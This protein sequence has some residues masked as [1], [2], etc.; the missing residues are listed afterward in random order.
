MSEEQIGQQV[1]PAQEAAAGA[2]PT[3]QARERH[4][5]LSQELT[6]HQYRYY[7]LDTPT[8]PDA[9]F[10][11]QLRELEALEAEF[12]A[13]RTPDSPTQRVGGSF[14]T[15]FTPVAHAERMLSLD[16]AF[17][18]EELAAWAERVERDAGGPVPYLCEL[19]VDGLAINLTY[20]NGR[21]VR[22]ATRG[23]GRTGE[24]VTANV[25]SIR[26]VPSQL[27]PS[28]DF[29]DIPEL[30]EVR[31]EIYF[32]VAAFAD[33]NAGLVEQGKAPF[34]NPRNAAAGSLRQKDPRVTASRPLRLVVHGIGARRGFQPTAQS[35]SYAAIRS[36]GLPTSDRWRVVPDLAGVAEY[37]AYYAKHRHDV[38]HEIDGVVVKVD[39]V[40]IQGRLG[41]TSRAPR[42]A[43]AFKYPP[44]EVTTKLLDIEVGVGRTGRVTPF[45]VLEPVH[46]AG[47]TVAQA[48]LHNAR[49]VERK[50]VLIG[51]TVV[52][53]KAGD[54]IPE[55]L[56]PVVDLRPAD[57]R[58]FVMP[59][60]CPSCGTPLAPAKESD[61]DIRCPNART[62]PGQIR[63]RV[64]YLAS[65][66]VLDIEA[67]GMKSA[68]A[69]LD[70]QIITNEGDLF[71]L[72]AGQLAASPFFV[73]KDGTLGSNAAKLL[74]N[75]AVARER[76]LWRVLVAL[77]IRHV[78]PTAAQALAR[79]FRSMDAIDAATEEELSSVDG[80]GPTIAASIREWFAVD[81]HREVVRKWAEAGVRMAE[82]AVDEGPRP[83]EGLTVV[84]TGTLA[85][86]SRD[87]A[88][89]AVQSRGGKVSGSVSK[90]TS[91]VVVGDNPGSKADKA[92]SLKVPVLDEAGFR[93]LLDAGPDA[94]REVAQAAG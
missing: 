52:L 73:N 77:S 30:V 48:T 78:G 21:L 43:I 44:E 45:A 14:S 94:A 6:E 42:W 1:S 69:L 20:E 3:P 81:W 2:E 74:D 23:D 39:P 9:D 11:R 53:R 54:V 13:L 92:I 83:L 62:C 4:A 67:L 57:A 40:S 71:Q 56:G 41:S 22:A 51:D 63:E 79:H 26:D 7:V 75:L 85:G 68:A 82:E 89:E 16:N 50:G 32:P 84:V 90:K 31:G 47:S 87:Q 27:T 46:V 29:P 61:V 55:V 17:A 33:L 86:F 36:W 65:R 12:P 28:A 34:A 66:R 60:T 19:K 10:D 76:E 70:G 49:E 38:E 91:F 72:D 15:D 5:T 8:I 80:V 37:I 59:T 24:D 35:E 25:R 64:F 93:V 58:P 18:D 88:A